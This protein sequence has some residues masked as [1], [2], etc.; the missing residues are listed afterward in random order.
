M[1]AAESDLGAASWPELVGQLRRVGQV[2]PSARGIRCINGNDLTSRDRPLSG[3][4]NVTPREHTHVSDCALR[5]QRDA[6]DCV[7]TEVDADEVRAASG[8]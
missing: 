2:R 8:H 7:R 5:V 4:V 6:R 1:F 3:F